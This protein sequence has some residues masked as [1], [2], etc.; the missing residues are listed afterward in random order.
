MLAKVDRATMAVSLEAR[1]LP[2]GT[3]LMEFSFGL[4]EAV[5]YDGPRLK[6]L[7]KKAY[8]EALPPRSHR[9][10][11]EGLQRTPGRVEEP[12]AGWR[13]S[14]AGDPRT[15]ARSAASIRVNS[16]RPVDAGER[17]RRPRTPRD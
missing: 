11:E 14:R 12:A 2:L 13:L 8:A 10:S 9:S 7:L 16:T 3:E 15:L 1:V 17:L 5:R 6:G 4:P